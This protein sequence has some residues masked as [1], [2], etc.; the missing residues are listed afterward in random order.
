MEVILRIDETHGRVQDRVELIDQ[1][2][3][4][5]RA[6][7]DEDPLDRVAAQGALLGHDQRAIHFG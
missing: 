7:E 5:V 3:A 6:T 2:R 1:D 4:I